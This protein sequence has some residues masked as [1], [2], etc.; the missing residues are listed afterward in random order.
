[1]ADYIT[2][3][4]CFKTSETGSSARNPGKRAS[5]HSQCRLL[6]FRVSLGAR[7]FVRVGQVSAKPKPNA[8][9]VEG[10][11]PCWI[12][13]QAQIR[14]LHWQNQANLFA[15]RMDI[16]PWLWFSTTTTRYEKTRSGL[17]LQLRTVHHGRL[18]LVRCQLQNPPTSYLVGQRVVVV[19]NQSQ[20]GMCICRVLGIGAGVSREC[21]GP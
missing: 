13:L 11:R 8:Q 16:P 20:G 4:A 10:K 6:T 5:R 15:P 21:F 17:L 12:I 3:Y 1:M 7:L 2:T 9:M 14:W 19:L 18:A